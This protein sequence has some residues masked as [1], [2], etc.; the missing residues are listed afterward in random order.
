MQPLHFR[1]GDDCLVVLPSAGYSR[2]HGHL[3]VCHCTLCLLWDSCKMLRAHEPMRQIVALPHF[4]AVITGTSGAVRPIPECVCERSRLPQLRAS[5]DRWEEEEDECD[6]SCRSN[7]ERA[8]FLSQ[9]QVVV[10]APWLSPLPDGSRCYVAR[11]R[12][13]S[14]RQRSLLE[15]ECRQQATWVPC[16]PE[17]QIALLRLA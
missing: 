5:V 8:E 16:M 2:T 9:A 4:C 7:S 6:I 15:S 12:C 13:T 17:P 3:K 11:V 14:T 10:W 1:A